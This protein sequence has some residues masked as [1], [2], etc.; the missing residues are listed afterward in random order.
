MPEKPRT[1]FEHVRRGRDAALAFVRDAGKTYFSDGTAERDFQD[2]HEQ[3]TLARAA[4]MG[5][6]GRLER[7]VA[8]LPG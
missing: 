7:S 2:E 3:Q 5:D 6:G 8:D 4:E 1:V